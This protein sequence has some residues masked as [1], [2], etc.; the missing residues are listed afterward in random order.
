MS[1]TGTKYKLDIDVNNLADPRVM[2]MNYINSD[3]VVLD[4]GCACGDLGI[5]LKQY[6]NSILYG[7]E[8]NHDSCVVAKNTGVY[9]DVVQFDLDTLT[10][11]NF[12]EYRA[13]FDFIVCNDI[14]EHLRNPE[15]TIKILKT[16]L[17]PDGMLIASIPN[18]AHASIKSNLLL[19]DFT[20]TPVGLLDETHIHLFT[21]KSIATMLASAGFLIQDSKFSFIEK[22][23]WQPNNPF[24]YIS[25]DVKKFILQDWHSYVCQYVIKAAVSN[26]HQSMMYTKNLSAVDINEKNAPDYISEY[27]KQQLNQTTIKDEQ[28]AMFNKHFAFLSDKIDSIYNLDDTSLNCMHKYYKKIKYKIRKYFNTVLITIAI[29]FF[30]L[31]LI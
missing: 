7:L 30:I 26:E 4:V 12:K 16:Y 29:C 1:E 19:N 2:T 28:I 10:E 8:Y 23:G 18:V 14:L 22:T 9:E 24:G 5:I 17:K 31:L 6:R 11:D 20:Y 25:D 13:K 27:R 15:N 21:Y 3:A